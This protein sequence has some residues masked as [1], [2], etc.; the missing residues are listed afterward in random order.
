MS[1][2]YLVVTPIGNLSEINQRALDILRSVSLIACEDTRN[3]GLL[4]KHFEIENKLISYHNFNEEEA[5]AK[6]LN[7]LLEGK[8]IALISD[9]GYPLI[10][11][12]GFTLVQACIDNK[13]EINVIGGNNAALN[14]LLGSGLPLQHYLYYGFLN[15]KSTAAKKELEALNNFPYTLIFYEA[16]H[17]IQRTL[18][19]MLEIF[20]DR[21]A[22]IARELSKLHETYHR[23]SL[24]ELMNDDYKGEIVLIVAGKQAEEVSVSEAELLKEI[25]DLIAQGKHHKEAA[26]ILAR[27]YNLKKNDLYN[28]YLKRDKEDA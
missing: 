1:K 24:S 17:R 7:I 6:L 25:E 9:A 10:S 16:P 18:K 27:K 23:G 3:S 26:Q 21:Q 4:L 2:L 8:D 11:D 5:T 14:G 19:L 22:C 13:I 20:G 12:P 28:L 15:S